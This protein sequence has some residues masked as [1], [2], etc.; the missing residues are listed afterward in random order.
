MYRFILA[1][2]VGLAVAPA[3]SGQIVRLPETACAEASASGDGFEVAAPSW[4]SRG[5][6]GG[7]GAGNGFVAVPGFELLPAYAHREYFYFVPEVSLGV[8][9]PVVIALHGTAG[10]PSRARTEA[11]VVRDLW[12]DAANRHGFAVVAPVAGSSLGSW[13][14]PDAPGAAPSD[15]DMITA[16]MRQME[17]RYDIERARRYL[18]GFSAGGHVAIDLALRPWHE[19]FGRRQFAAIAI[20]AGTLAGQACRGGTTSEC[21]LALHD[22]FPR[23]PLQVMIG[24][25]DPLVAQVVADAPRFRSQGWTNLRDYQ[26]LTFGGGHWVEPTHPQQHWDWLCQYARRLDPIERFRLRPYTP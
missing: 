10:S 2:V 7:P 4:P 5:V 11:R 26:L 17:S 22:A 6:G 14:A 19:G 21:D 15:Y 12:T 18:W 20:N 9:M 1:I 13:L 16:V 8:V 3:V 23:L 24:D 25:L